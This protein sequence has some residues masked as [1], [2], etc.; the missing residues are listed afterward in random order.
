MSKREILQSSQMMKLMVIQKK[1][2]QL[3][4]LGKYVLII[5]YISIDNYSSTK[6]CFIYT[7]A[8][9]K[10]LLCTRPGFLQTT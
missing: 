4:V 5:N 3:K 1:L 6:T 7:T 8:Y 2:S 10:Y 9:N